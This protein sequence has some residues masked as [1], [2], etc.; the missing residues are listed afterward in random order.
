L[1]VLSARPWLLGYI[2]NRDRLWRTPAEKL[3]IPLLETGQGMIRKSGYR[4][5]E[6]IM[7]HQMPRVAIDFNLKRMRSGARLFVFVQIAFA[8]VCELFPRLGYCL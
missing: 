8:Q 6:K 2:A 3:G 4:F 7:P 1:H 5:S